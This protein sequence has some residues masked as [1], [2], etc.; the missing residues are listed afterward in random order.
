MTKTVFRPLRLT[1]SAWTPSRWSPTSP[2]RSGGTSASGFTTATSTGASS[3][4]E[5]E[6]SRIPTCFSK[7]GIQ[8]YVCRY[9]KIYLTKW[10]VDKREIWW[11]SKQGSLTKMGR[12]STIDLLIK[13]GCFVKKVNNRVR[14]IRSWLKLVSTRRSTVQSLPFQYDFH[15]ASL[16]W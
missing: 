16:E 15:A 1:T 11:N 13:K 12:Q 5:S 4:A 6:T 10:R 7:L 9:W 2:S 3:S 14:I 8:S